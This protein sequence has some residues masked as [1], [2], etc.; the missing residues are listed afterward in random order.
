MTGGNPFDHMI[1]CNKTMEKKYCIIGGR[2]SGDL[3][4]NAPEG[5]R[6]QQIIAPMT[7]V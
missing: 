1:I 5:S 3:L 2:S 6:V 7:H 4:N